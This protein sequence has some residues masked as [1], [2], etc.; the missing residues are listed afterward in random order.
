MSLA[1]AFYKGPPTD[2]PH[3]ISHY[4]IRLWTWSKYSHAELVI[5]GVC[6]SS[7]L[8]DGGVR[9]KY[10]DLASGRWDVLPVKGNAADALWW[11][12]QH[13]GQGYDWLNVQRFILP[14]IPQD[15][16]KWVCFEAVAA[17]LGLAG[18]H[19][20]TAKDL[21]AWALDNPPIDF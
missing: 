19:K 15:K 5:D 17:M 14:F 13:K 18:A 16:N 3:I 11:Y 4:A 8:R 1:I 21:Y 2:L 12:Q 20:L 6:Y 10:I 9:S 7:S